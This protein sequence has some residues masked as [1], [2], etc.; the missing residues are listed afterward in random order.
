FGKHRIS[1]LGLFYSNDEI[2]AFA[3]DFTSSIPERFLV[4]AGRGTHSYDD[5]YF[6]A[7]NFGYNGSEL[8]APDN[9]F[10][11]FP[12]FGLGWVVSN[13]EFFEPLTN[14][15]SFLKFRYSDGITGIG[16]INGRRFAYLDILSDN[17]P[18]YT[19]G[20]NF[21]HDSGF[22]INDFGVDIGWAESRKQNLGVEL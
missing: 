15:I 4:L 13:E 9:R 1:G 8:F 7:A 12:A 11:I 21:N 18:G 22:Q 6:V 20:R 10:G 2:N 3:G 14:V 19:F 16:R 5:R 17:A